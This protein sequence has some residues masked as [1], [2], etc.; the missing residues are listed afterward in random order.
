MSR[1]GS[2]CPG[3]PRGPRGRLHRCL[4]GHLR[5]HK[6][7]DWEGAEEGINFHRFQGDEGLN[8]TYVRS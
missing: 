1:R 4:V 7:C 2:E 8:M 3:Q 5:T 6:G